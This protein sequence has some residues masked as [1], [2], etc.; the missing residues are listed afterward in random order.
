MDNFKEISAFL[1]DAPVFLQP[2]WLEALSEGNVCYS[3]VRR[4][5]QIAAV[6][7]YIAKKLGGFQF[8][9][10]PIKSPYLGPWLKLNPAKYAKQLAEQKDLLTK[11]IEGLPPVAT[12]YQA[13]HPEITNWLPFY[14]QGFHQTTRY[15]YRIENTQS[16]NDV[17]AGTTEGIRT[18]IRKAQKALSVEYSDNFTDVILLHKKTCERQGFR[19]RHTDVEMLS[20]HKAC[21]EKKCSRVIL[22]RGSDG[23]L[24]AGA[25]F[26]WD[27]KWLYYYTSGA[28]PTL[29]KSGA[30]SLI[31]WKGIELA[32]KMGLGFDFE[33]SMHEPIEKFFRSFGAKQ[34]PY[35]FISKESK[36][37]LLRIVALMRKSKG[38]LQ[39]FLRRF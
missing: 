12:F 24:H 25:Y 5:H 16:L 10:G 27:S 15:T 13:F 39:E 21:M 30:G 4:G 36:R 9:E 8:I 20:L 32:S 18:D 37:P 1:E 2:W 35:F 31:V 26:I 3:I 17:W 38:L 11:L 34:V 7:P 33:G 22:A 28:D 23:Q 6:M 14:W 29:R 19:F